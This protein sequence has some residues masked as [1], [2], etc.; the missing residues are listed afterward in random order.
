M[1]YILH[2]SKIDSKNDT[3]KDCDIIYL[4]HCGTLPPRI[5]QIQHLF[6]SRLKT[7]AL[8]FSTRHG[9]FYN[10]EGLTEEGEELSR[11]ESDEL[12]M[13]INSGFM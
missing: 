2:N 7:L 6:S 10:A 11:R 1:D 4:D 5:W 13:R 12:R 9:N 8:T 3:Y